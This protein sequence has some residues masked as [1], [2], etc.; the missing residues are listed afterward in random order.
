[1][2][3]MLEREQDPRIL[4]SESELLY[5]KYLGTAF[6]NKVAGNSV[7]YRNRPHLPLSFG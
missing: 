4:H 1:M 6:L 3:V 7:E 2:A 5:F